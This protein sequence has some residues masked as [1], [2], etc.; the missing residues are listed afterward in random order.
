M[1]INFYYLIFVLWKKYL[2]GKFDAIPIQ[3]AFLFHIFIKIPI[4]FVIK[5]WKNLQGKPIAKSYN[6][7]GK[8][9]CKIFY[10]FRYQCFVKN[11]FSKLNC[12]ISE[13]WTIKIILGVG[14][15]TRTMTLSEDGMSLCI[16]CFDF[17][18]KL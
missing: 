12:Q 16:T 17:I 15:W 5:A 3:L 9:F 10:G 14:L 6:P 2:V 13:W 18:N 11:Q 4:I 8:L 1:L 7:I